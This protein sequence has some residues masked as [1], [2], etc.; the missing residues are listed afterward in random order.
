[1]N[2]VKA[3]VSLA[4]ARRLGDQRSPPIVACDALTDQIR[5]KLIALALGV[6]LLL[7]IGCVNVTNLLVTQAIRRKRELALRETLGARPGRLIRQLFTENVVLIAAGSVFCLLVAVAVLK[8][9]PT[10]FP[11]GTPRLA[12]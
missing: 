3:D 4:Y 2:Q 10:M 11:P 8:L 6:F 12:S 5:P 9:F 1:M 7:L